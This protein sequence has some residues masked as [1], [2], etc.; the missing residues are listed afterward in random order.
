VIEVSQ[1]GDSCY[2]IEFFPNVQTDAS[3][4]YA[5]AVPIST[6]GILYAASST[7]SFWM[8][9]IGGPT[10][11]VTD[12]YAS[13]CCTSSGATLTWVINPDQ[14]QSSPIQFDTS[15][16]ED[17]NIVGAA[18]N[19]CLL[20]NPYCSG[21][22]SATFTSG[23]GT[24]NYC[25]YNN[26]GLVGAQSAETSNM[27]YG[28]LSQ[29]LCNGGNEKWYYQTFAPGT[30][31]GPS[32]GIQTVNQN[33]A[34]ITGYYVG[35]YNSS[36]SLINHGFSPVTFSGLTVGSNYYVEPDNYGSCAFNHWQDT[37]STTR[38]RAFTAASS[39]TFVAVY[40]CS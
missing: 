24:I 6:S 4:V 19:L 15:S 40:D 5:A 13:A 28:A 31:G 39:Q 25:S 17:F 27:V 33:G 7:I 29:L 8:S 34:T 38:D 30:L 10:Y 23:Y 26:A 21:Y 18:S 2:S 9:C 14:L 1:S 11:T 3:L 36:G 16:K 20:G 37:G 12:F 32:I 35:L 22:G